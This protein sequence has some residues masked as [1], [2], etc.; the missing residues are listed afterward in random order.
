M[1]T[2]G[3]GIRI[4]TETMQTTPTESQAGQ[5]AVNPDDSTM[6]NPDTSDAVNP[7]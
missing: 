3:I 6:L 5:I 4:P 2:L 7:S 1:M